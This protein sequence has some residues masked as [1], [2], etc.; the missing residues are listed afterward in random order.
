MTQQGQ[1]NDGALDINATG[2]N[3]GV[4]TYSWA[5]P[6]GFTA[7]TQDISSLAAGDY[8]VT[9]KDVKGCQTVQTYT[10]TKACLIC[11]ASA[12]NIVNS[13]VTDGCYSV[14]IPP[15]ASGPFILSWKSSTNPVAQTKT[16]SDYL[17]ETCN[18]PAGI[19]MVTVTDATNTSFE[20]PTFSLAQ[21]P[22]V[23]VTST[24]VNSNLDNKNGSITLSS[25]PG[26]ALSYDWSMSPTIV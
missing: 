6:S 24:V 18:L 14:Q 26:L 17:I 13:C 22:P 2:G 1:T 12:V 9:V 21:R 5:G 25:G 15:S 19:Y 10:V 7:N 20:L 3:T 11:D 23:A 16:S 4:I 8:T